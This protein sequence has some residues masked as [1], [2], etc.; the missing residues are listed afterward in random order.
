MGETLV[1]SLLGIMNSILFILAFLFMDF[2]DKIKHTTKSCICFRTGMV[3]LIFYFID[4]FTF[5]E[6]YYIFWSFFVIAQITVIAEFI[7]KNKTT[8]K[9][10]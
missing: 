3:S 5:V 6:N 1:E 9:V 10:N 2:S 8:K 4:K 7:F